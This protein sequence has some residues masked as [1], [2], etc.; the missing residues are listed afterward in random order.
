MLRSW[1]TPGRKFRLL[2]SEIL[3]LHKTPMDGIETFAGTY[4]PGPVEIGVSSHVPPA[5][6]LVP[7]LM[8]D[9]CTYV[10][11]RWSRRTALHLCAYV[12]WRMNWIHPFTDGNGRTARVT[13]YIVLCAKLGHELPGV[14]TVPEQIAADKRPYYDALESADRAAKRGKLQLDQMEALLERYLA[15]QLYEIHRRARSQRIGNPRPRRLH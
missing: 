11:T 15:K 5:A 12:M 10:N 9:M 7:S 6:H 1:L 3:Q 2:T 14:K 13:A 8:E 4:R